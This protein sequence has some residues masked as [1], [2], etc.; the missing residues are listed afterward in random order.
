MSQKI[1]FFNEEIQFTLKNKMHLRK[2]VTDTLESENFELGELNFIFCS[3]TYLLKI[4]QEYLNHNTFTDIIT[5]DNSEENK[6]ISGDIFISI[7]RVIENAN[8]LSIDFNDE[9]HRVMIHGVL[10]LMGYPDKKKEEKYLMTAKED[11]YLAR[12]W[13]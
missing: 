12:R 1:Q 4:N 6:E 5:F 7:D 11:H 3:D 9:L 10:H 8:S 2:W 13:S